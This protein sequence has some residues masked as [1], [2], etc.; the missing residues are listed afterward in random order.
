MSGTDYGMVELA[1]T[2]PG[3]L[4]LLQGGALPRGDVLRIAALLVQEV[5]ETLDTHTS[6]CA[7]CDL[8]K[9]RNWKEK[10][11]HDRLKGLPDKLR[12][13]AEEAGRTRC[14]QC[15]CPLARGDDAHCQVCR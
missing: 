10:N 6:S 2:P 12:R 3:A 1:S 7:A 14:R 13:M 8:H 15:H 11:L 9:A 5:A 4:A